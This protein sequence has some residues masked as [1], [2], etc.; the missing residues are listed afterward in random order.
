MICRNR[1]PFLLFHNDYFFSPQFVNLQHILVTEHFSVFSLY[2]NFIPAIFICIHLTNKGFTV[3]FFFFHFLF[4]HLSPLPPL[5][6][7]WRAFY[8]DSFFNHFRWWNSIN[9]NICVCPIVYSH[10]PQ[11]TFNGMLARIEKRVSINYN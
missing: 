5:P 11:P 8:F 4:F 1:R 3:C 7:F 9:L 6:P 10:W 2:F